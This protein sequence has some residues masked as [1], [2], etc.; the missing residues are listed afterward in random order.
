[1]YKAYL[2]DLDGTMYEGTRVI[3]SAV[4]FV[5]W[6]AEQGVPYLFVSNNSTKSAQQVADKLQ[7]IG[8]L[9]VSENQVITSAQVAASTVA[10]EFSGVPTLMI[11]ESGLRNELL[12]VGTKLMEDETL[13]EVVVVGLDTQ[14]TYEKLAQATVAIRRGATFIATNRDTNIPTERG[15][16]PGAG[17]LIQL[18]VTATGVEPRVMGKPEPAIMMAALQRLGLSECEVVMVGDNYQTDILAGINANIDTLW[19][20]TGIHRRA[21]IQAQSVQ[22]THLV[23]DL[24]EWQTVFIKE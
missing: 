16:L 12:A 2:F 8:C 6:L 7:A 1:M 5:N 23:N 22:P 20:D 19:V 11:G 14:V 10:A 18:L 21:Y 13:A 3:E 9:H 15:L 4:T 24:L 17:S